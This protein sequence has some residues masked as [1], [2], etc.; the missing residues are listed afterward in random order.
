MNQ[1]MGSNF[2]FFSFKFSVLQNFFHAILFLGIDYQGF[3]M[4]NQEKQN[5]R[6]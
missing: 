2:T 3:F 5:K 1:S 4:V 6:V